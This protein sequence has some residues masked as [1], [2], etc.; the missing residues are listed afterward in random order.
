YDLTSFHLVSQYVE[1]LEH[2]FATRLTFSWHENTR[3]LHLNNAFTRPERVLMDTMIERTEQDLMTDRI[4]KRWIERWALHE[5]M[6]MLAQIRGKYS[7]LPGAGGGISLNAADLQSQ[8]MQLREELLA[9]LEDYVAD[10]P[11]DVG[12]HST[13]I[14]G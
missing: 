5:A 8:A 7:T 11:E 13:F 1:Q 14:L 2:L 4:T 6:L 12:M 3:T 9:E 10:T